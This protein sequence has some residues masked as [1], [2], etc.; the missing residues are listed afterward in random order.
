MPFRDLFGHRRVLGLLSR[1]IQTDSLP[2]SLIFAGPDGVGK[3]LAAVA[4]AQALNCLAPVAGADGGR[5]ACGRCTSCRKIDRR[6]HPDVTVVAPEEGTAIKIEQIREVVGQT[7][8]RP[9]EG[10]SRVVVIDGA[11]LMGD[12]AQN[13]L[14]KTLEEPPPRNVFVL[15]T[16]RPDALLDTI[17]SRCC[18]LRFG[19]VA[20]HDLA[21]AL[22][23]RHEFDEADAHAT[24]ALAGG[25]FARALA[26]GGSELA[27]ARAVA[28]GILI[29][30]SRA[31]DPRLRLACGAAL[32]EGAAKKGKKQRESKSG[33]PDRAVL[34]V[35][36]RALQALLRDLAVLTT[37]APEAALVNPDLRADLEPL[38]RAWDRDRVARAYAAVGRA[39]AAVERHN[40]STKIVADWLAF[41]L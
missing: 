12:D 28:A 30:A 17:R 22:T 27:D 24:A 10:R 3:R 13:A 21:G 34:A 11:D 36:L 4:A 6:L 25:S 33:T 37:R 19:P 26:S 7:A 15:V 35:R 31:A 39:L 18:L 32:I 29:E 14:L 8:Y 1:A 20:A 23:A 40:A 9:F 5:D 16:N 2:P 41:Q 38:A